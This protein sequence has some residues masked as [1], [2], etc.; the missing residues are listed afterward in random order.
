MKTNTKPSGLERATL[1]AARAAQLQAQVEA[2]VAEMARIQAEHDADEVA[3]AAALAAEEADYD[4]AYDD[5]VAMWEDSDDFLD[6]GL[7]PEYDYRPSAA[8]EA[9]G[10]ALEAEDTYEIVL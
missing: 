1:R 7:E 8:L 10:E 6:G 5:H 2:I 3:H 4:T 9:W